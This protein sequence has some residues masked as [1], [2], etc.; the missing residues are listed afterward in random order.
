LTPTDRFWSS[1]PV[2]R[3]PSN[4]SAVFFDSGQAYSFAPSLT[5]YVRCVR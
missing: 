1:S 5:S 2:A 4:V 3:S